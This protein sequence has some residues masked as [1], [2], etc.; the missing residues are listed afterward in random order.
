MLPPSTPLLPAR[1]AP[2]RPAPQHPA[3][4]ARPRPL[5]RC[6]PRDSMAGVDLVRAE[7]VAIAAAKEAGEYG[8][9]SPSLLTREGGARC[10][11]LTLDTAQE[12]SYRPPSTGRSTSRRKVGCIFCALG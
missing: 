6:L 12:P 2:A 3:L 5:R 10:T 9:G 7:H 1:P 11:F 8:V 4:Q